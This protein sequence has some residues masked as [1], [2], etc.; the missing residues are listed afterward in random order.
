MSRSEYDAFRSLMPTPPATDTAKLRTIDVLKYE[1]AKLKAT[2]TCPPS[3]HE[4]VVHMRRCPL[5]G[6]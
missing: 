6:T 2:C 4:R 1:A 5:R 3:R